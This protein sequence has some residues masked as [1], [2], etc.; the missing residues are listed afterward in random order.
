MVKVDGSTEGPS[1]TEIRGRKHKLAFRPVR[2]VDPK[3]ACR[4]SFMKAEPSIYNA[5]LSPI[6][7]YLFLGK[8]TPVKPRYASIQKADL[9]A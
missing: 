7:S 1:V 2:L 9:N 8:Q 4:R 3:R 5:T 6:L